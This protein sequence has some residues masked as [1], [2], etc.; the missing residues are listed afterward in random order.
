MHANIVLIGDPKQLDAVT[1]SDWSI[2]MGFKTSWM[3]QLSE[4]SLY[5]RRTE[6]GDFNQ[7]FITQLIQNYRSHKAILKI[8][9][10]LFYENS[11]K[12]IASPG[13]LNHFSV[14]THFL[15]RHSEVIF[16]MCRNNR[17][18]CRRF[19]CEEVSD[20]IQICARLLPKTRRRYEVIS[21]IHPGI[22]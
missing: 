5:K 17:T 11:L 18:G 6:T 4:T 12:A 22:R 8:P 21:L 2:K 19:T 20:Y 3:E 10:E 16:F 15:N 9:N 1:K 7:T 13:S 14:W